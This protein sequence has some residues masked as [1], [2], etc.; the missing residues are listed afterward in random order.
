M[1]RI[2]KIFFKKNSVSENEGG[3]VL[4]Y[5][6]LNKPFFSLFLENGKYRI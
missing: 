2:L 3:I 6:Q 1:D 4:N 5:T